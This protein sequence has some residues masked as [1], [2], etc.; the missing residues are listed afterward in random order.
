V[1]H[2]ALTDAQPWAESSKLSI[3]SI[4]A[5]LDAALSVQLFARLASE[6]DVST[7]TTPVLT[8]DLV[9][10]ILAMQ[11]V[12]WQISRAYASDET[13]SDYAI[14]LL[15]MAE[16]LIQGLLDGTTILIEVPLVGVT[17]NDPGFYP[18]DDSSSLC[19]T[20]YDTSLGGPKFT[21]GVVW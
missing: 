17:N 11:Y 9:S 12:S 5:N 10:S 14:R 2:I 21:M 3:T 4:D 20:V 15:G 1:V 6:F 19:P 8:P 18:S 16:T 13:E 7:W